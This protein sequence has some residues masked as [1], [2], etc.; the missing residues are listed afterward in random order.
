MIYLKTSIGVELRGEDMLMSSLQGNLSDGAFTHFKRIANCRQTNTETLRQEIQQFFRSYGLSKDNIVLGIPRRD[1]VLR[2]LDLPPEVEDNLKQVV[3]YQV[4]SFEPTEE[5]KFYYDYSVLNAAGASKRLSIMLT[6][7]RKSTLDE[8]LRFLRTVGI[9]P[10]RVLGSSMG[11]AN[12]FLQNGKNFQDKTCILVDLGASSM[13]LLALSDGAVVYSREV[14]KE[15]KD[16]WKDL[17]FKEINSAA[18]KI[19]LTPEGTLDHLILAGESSESAYEEIRAAVP[20]CKLIKS[21][22]PIA[23]PGENKPF[24]QQAACAL[25]LAYTGMAGN[26]AVRMNLLPDDL[27]MRQTRWAYVP[28][29]ILGLAVLVL[30]AALGSHRMIQNRMLLRELNEKINSIKGQVARAQ[31]TRKQAE[32]ME[33]TVLSVEDLLRKRDMNLEILQELTTILPPDTYLNNYSNKDGVIQIGGL[34]SSPYDLMPK[35]EKSPLLKDVVAR[36]TFPKDNTT[37][38][39]RFSFEMK[40]ER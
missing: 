28:A 3:Q 20:E 26:P 2:Y 6:M 37:G 7:V 12:L 31:S 36:G 16:S 1:V 15:D 4:Q 13:E 11:L 19:R 34:S 5:D 22:L 9:R 10:T 24:V 23:V 14:T 38:K 32:I 8:H 27:R 18:S 39:D 33:K 40:M 35:L 25:G 29:V 17:I 21:V 30:L